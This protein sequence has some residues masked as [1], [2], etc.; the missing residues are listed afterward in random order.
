MI[1][2]SVGM[3]Q[4]SVCRNSAVVPLPGWCAV[5]YC[6]HLCSHFGLG[7]VRVLVAKANSLGISATVEEGSRWSASDADDVNTFLSAVAKGETVGYV[8][9][10]VPSPLWTLQMISKKRNLT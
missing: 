3:S 2:F 4:A 9:Y 7:L 8:G 6:V 5:K 1:H 10:C